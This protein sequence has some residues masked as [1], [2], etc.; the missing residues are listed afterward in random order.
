MGPFPEQ[1]QANTTD[2][3]HQGLGN[4]AFSAN[5]DTANT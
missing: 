1:F 3:W 5:Q 4:H 2:F